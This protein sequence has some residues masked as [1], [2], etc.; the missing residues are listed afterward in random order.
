[1]LFPFPSDDSNASIGQIIARC[2]EQ[3]SNSITEDTLRDWQECGMLCLIGKDSDMVW[4]MKDNYTIIMQTGPV[5]RWIY[6]KQ[7]LVVFQ[8]V[9][10]TK[11]HDD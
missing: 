7:Y 1:M 11:E 3:D 9:R 10:T 6:Y 4:P 8:L 5:K 2:R